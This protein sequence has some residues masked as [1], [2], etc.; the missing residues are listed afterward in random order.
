MTYRGDRIDIRYRMMNSIGLLL[1]A[2]VFLA[3]CAATPYPSVEVYMEPIE[4]RFNAHIDPETAAATVEKK[5]VA[6]TIEPI[7]EVELFA[8]T[9]DPKL[10]PILSLSGMVLL[11]RSTRCLGLPFITATTGAFLLMT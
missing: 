6:V 3:G 2:G 1:L 11:N 5:G 10:N 4:G 8:L 9:E 7:D